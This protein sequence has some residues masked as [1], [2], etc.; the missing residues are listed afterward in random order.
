MDKLME[1]IAHDCVVLMNRKTV[2]QGRDAMKP[3]YQLDFDNGHKVTIR[4]NK[5]IEKEETIGV[6]CVLRADTKKV[7]VDVTY[8]IRK[9]DG[10]MYIHEIHS[11]SPITNNSP[12][13][14]TAS[15]SSSQRQIGSGEFQR[16]P[17]S[18]LFT[19]SPR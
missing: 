14:S 19:S 5:V 17:S 6:R 3:S 2:T 1:H 13:D 9:R 4:K 8:W 10:K 12:N 7:D 15:P 11:V 18:S 16:S